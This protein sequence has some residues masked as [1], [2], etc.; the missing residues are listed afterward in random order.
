M[1][2]P[3]PTV[4]VPLDGSKSALG[5]LPVAQR[6][7][8]LAKAHLRILHVTETARPLGETAASIGLEPAD[9]RGGVLE[10]RAGDPAQAIVAA[11]ADRGSSLIVM[12]AHSAEPAGAI[13]D[14]ALAVLSGAACPVVLVDPARAPA[15]WDLRRVLALHDG[16][17]AVSHALE[18]AGELARQAGAELVVLQ[19]AHEACAEEAGSIA[20]PA[21]VDQVQYSWPGWSAEFLH[22][23]AS[24]CPLA[25]VPVRLRLAHGEPAVETVR[26]AGEEAVDLIVM[27]WKGEAAETL[28]VLLR[29]APCPIMVTRG[30]GRAPGHSPA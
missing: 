18:P 12:C 25:D 26:V 29:D 19:V 15:G 21:Y 17:P 27:A 16:S 10:A 11:A 5:V 13:S 4:L 1:T 2:N 20:P 14:T 6:L 9:L 28:E 7:A 30:A 22:R 23:L 8:G 3:D 24:L